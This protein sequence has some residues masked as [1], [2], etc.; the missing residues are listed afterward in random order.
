MTG[1]DNLYQ[2]VL[3]SEYTNF[4]IVRMNG[5]TADNNWENKWNQTVDLTYSDSANLVIA[6]GWNGA[7][8]NVTQSAKQ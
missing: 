7:I 4:I 3:P 8:F 1:S 5:A 2:S 6:T